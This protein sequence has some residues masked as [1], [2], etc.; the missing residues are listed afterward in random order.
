M[1]K[2]KYIKLFDTFQV[3]ETTLYGG[4]NPYDIY[5]Y[6]RNKDHEKYKKIENSGIKEIYLSDLIDTNEG[7][8]L[9]GDYFDGFLKLFKELNLKINLK[10]A[11]I[12]HPRVL[13]TIKNTLIKNNLVKL[14]D[15]INANVFKESD[16]NSQNW[17][18]EVLKKIDDTNN[19]ELTTMVQIIKD[20]I[21]K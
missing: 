7:L 8:A 15:L 9:L 10:K 19:N 3:N 20:K 13:L 21:K 1:K 6:L 11:N 17:T 16:L 4:V 14:E 2:M 5:S 18:S 12:E